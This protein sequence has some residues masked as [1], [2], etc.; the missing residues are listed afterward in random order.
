M[1][2]IA[3]SFGRAFIVG[4]LVPSTLFVAFFLLVFQGYSLNQ[5]QADS[6]LSENA[7]ELMASLAVPLAFLLLAF[8]TVIIKLY[9]G[10]LGVARHLFAGLLARNRS[11]H[12]ALYENLLVFRDQYANTTEETKRGA[13]AHAI[14]K[15]WIRILPEFDCCRLPLDRRRVMPTRMGNVFATIEEYPSVR[16]GMDGMF[17][18]PRLIPVIPEE[19]NRMIS[20]ENVSFTFLLNLSLLSAVFGVAALAGVFL[21]DSGWPLFGVGVVALGIFYALYRLATVALITMGELMKSSFDLYRHEIL[22]RMQIEVPADIGEERQLW[23]TLTN[24]LTS[25]EPFYYPGSPETR[26]PEQ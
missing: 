16:Y 25:G 17:Y 3:F 21:T 8:N 19:F 11:R 6:L 7:L 22:H 18:W 20:N 4:G 1:F 24:Y 13:L 5:G 10:N 9:E 12:Q 15:E 14:E 26:R 2:G 23:Y